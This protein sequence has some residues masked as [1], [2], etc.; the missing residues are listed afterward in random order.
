MKQNTR[1]LNVT[2][3]CIAVYNSGID[4]P[5]DLSFEEA[6]EYVKA[7]MDEIPVGV[8]EYIGGSE[9]LD[10]ENCDFNDD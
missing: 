10:E 1:R 6:I 9:T 2:V 4:V 3:Q 5:A 8:L 7:H